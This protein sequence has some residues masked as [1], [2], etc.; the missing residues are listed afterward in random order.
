MNLNT[1][2]SINKKRTEL[3]QLLPDEIRYKIYIEYFKPVFKERRIMRILELENKDLHRVDSQRS[4]VHSRLLFLI[5]NVLY[6]EDEL[7]LRLLIRSNEKFASTY[8]LWL[9]NNLGFEL[10]KDPIDRFAVKWIL[11]TFH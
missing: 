6:G 1:I 4:K 2:R 3:I 7:L 5:R 8:E 10:I 11:K 9:N